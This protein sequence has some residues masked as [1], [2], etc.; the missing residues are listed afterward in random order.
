MIDTHTHLYDEQFNDDRNDMIQRAIQSGVEKM[1]LP[2]CDS[3]TVAGMLDVE[4]DFPDHCFAMMGLHPCYV[5]DRVEDELRIVREWLDKRTFC[6]VGEIGLDYYWDK[7]FAEAQQ[8]AFRTQI[9]WA[10][11]FDIPIV[12]HTREATKDTIDIVK[13]YAPKGIRG[14]FHCFSGSF[15][16]AM[17]IIGMGFYLGIGG[18]LTYKNAGLQEVVQKIDLQHLILETDAPYLTPAPHRGK[19]NESSYVNLVAQKLAELKSVALAEVERITTEN[20]LKLFQ[21]I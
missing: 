11:E 7:T 18:V 10:L 15:E 19:R 2:N 8:K 12:I 17:Q 4:Q 3:G 5:N 6:A 20:A 16:S 13:E 9:E 14:V 21:H 1:Y